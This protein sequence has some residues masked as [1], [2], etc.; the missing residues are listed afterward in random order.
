[1]VFLDLRFFYII[2]LF[3]VECSIVPSLISL[4][5]YINKIFP[6]ETIIK[7]AKKGGKTDRK[8]YHPYMVSEKYTKKSIDEENSSLFMNSI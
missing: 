1:M 5:F 8:P 7:N 3:T 6:I 2:S 4:Y